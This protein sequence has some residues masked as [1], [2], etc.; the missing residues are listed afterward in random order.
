MGK[1]SGRT[2]FLGGELSGHFVFFF[3]GIEFQ[4]IKD[5]KWQLVL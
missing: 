3:G 4:D 1:C 5:G 2:A